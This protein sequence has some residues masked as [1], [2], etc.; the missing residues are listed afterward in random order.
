M[1]Y[2]APTVNYCATIDGTYTSLTGIQTVSIS[3]GRQRFQDNFTQT[4]CTIELIPA[5]TY[6][7]PLA[8]GQFIDV[9][10]A[11][12]DTSPCYFNGRI[13]DIQ[14][15]YSIPYNSGTGYAPQDRIIITA[16]GPTGALGTS[17]LSNYL[18]G[19]TDCTDAI[20]QLALSVGIYATFQQYASVQC[21]TT[22]NVNGGTLDLVNAL[23][24]TSQYFI[25]DLDQLRTY[26]DGSVTANLYP[27]G[28]GNTSF[29]FSDSGTAGAY[30]FSDL[31]YLSSVQNTFNQVQVSP[32]G[33]ATQTAT[34]G[35]APYNTLPYQTYNKTTS[36]ALSLANYI[37]AVQSVTT[38]VPFSV[39]TSTLLD[40]SVTALSV[41][42][43]RL[44]TFLFDTKPMNLGASV[45]VIFRG[46][47]VTATIQGINTTF[48]DDYATVQLFLSPSLSSSFT[49]D[50]TVLGVLDT[51]R[52]GYL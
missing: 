3:R 28:Q 2:T 8:V 40:S 47:T 37:L 32:A 17:S 33:L 25:D 44:N 50:S 48:Y 24:R 18:L 49:L 52:L 5:T 22:L 10:N 46:T 23:L 38:P 13:T 36:D 26:I 51:N 16:T 35:S 12:T 15:N 9:R 34:S 7:L 6:A 43:D 21:S 11:N 45:T 29:T 42:N 31:Q 41:V 19:T 30:K 20:Y 27:A 14:R 4:N 1:P 39:T